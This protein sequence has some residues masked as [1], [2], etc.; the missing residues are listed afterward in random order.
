M[1][2]GTSN[3]LA[4]RSAD[5]DRGA[6]GPEGEI[7]AARAPREVGNHQDRDNAKDSRPH[8]IQNNVVTEQ[9]HGNSGQ[10]VSRRVESLVA[11]L[12]AIEQPMSDDS[13]GNGADSRTEDAR[14]AANQDLGPHH[15]P[16]GRYQRNQQCAHGQGD[17]PCGNERAFGSET[18]NQRARRSLRQDSGDSANGQR[19]SH[20]LLV[21]PVSGEVDGEEGSDSRLDV[22]EKEIQPV[23]TAERSGGRRFD[24]LCFRCVGVPSTILPLY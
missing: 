8:A 3:D 6:D 12:A 9:A 22:G 20:A 4:E 15:G 7:K 1:H 5:A 19:D 13:E 14:R 24:I 2:D 21:P 23:Q 11:S 10:D 18:V 17:D 16:K